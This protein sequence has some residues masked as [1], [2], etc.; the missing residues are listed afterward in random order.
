MGTVALF[1]AIALD[2]F[3]HLLFFLKL[4]L[5]YYFSFLFP[6]FVASVESCWCRMGLGE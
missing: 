6:V 5:L 1:L 4:R 3:F 2:L